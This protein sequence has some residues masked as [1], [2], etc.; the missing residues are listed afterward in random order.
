MII[1]LKLALL[2]FDNEFK[3]I[4]DPS[5]NGVDVNAAM[6]MEEHLKDQCNPIITFNSRIYQWVYTIVYKVPNFDVNVP[7]Y[8][9]LPSTSW[10][11]FLQ[12]NIIVLWDFWVLWT[13]LYLRLDE[14]DNWFDKVKLL[15]YQ[16][17]LN[18]FDNKVVVTPYNAGH[19][20]GEHI[21]VNHEKNRSG[22]LCTSLESFKGLF[23]KQ[24][25]LYLAINW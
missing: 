7:V 12:W 16:Q 15:K 4:A 10:G 8:S 9:T 14:V 17:S 25:F 20:L 5:W 18:L 19:S 2:E 6:F 23:S 11:E 3:L 1:L 13:R 22:N 21:L 24:C